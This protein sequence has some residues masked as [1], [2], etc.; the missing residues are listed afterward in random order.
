MKPPSRTWLLAGLMAAV[1]L[2]GWSITLRQA[3]SSTVLVEAGLVL[4]LPNA[5]ANDHPVT[6][7]W[8][9]AAQ[10]EGLSLQPMSDDA[11]VQALANHQSLPGVILPDT[12]HRQASDMLVNALHHY[13]QQGGQL[14]VAFDAALLDPQQ[15]A[16][17]A[18]QSRLSPL[19][20][21]VYA[22][23][24]QM[25]DATTA[26]GP[27][28]MSRKAE[29]TLAI[30]PGKLDFEGDQASAWGELTTYGYKT[31]SYSHYRTLPSD[32]S[33]TL[34][35][36]AQG[37]TVVSTHH[38]GQ[39]S[40]LFA[41]LPLG[42][43]KTQ[44][45]SYLL[46]RLLSHFAVAMVHQP[47]LA[48]T[49]GAQGGMVLNLHVDS[50]AAQ[51]HLQSLEAAGWFDQ[52]PYSI[53]I[54]AGPDTY[55]PGDHMGID[56]P[57]NPWMQGFL[58]RQHAKGHEIGNH[59]G[60]MHN[61]FGYG[62]TQDNRER[63]EPFL[64]LNHTAVSL[65]IGER[66]TSY[67]APMGN[68][69][70]W[71]TDWLAAHEFK[72][73]YTTSDSGL[74]PTRSYI[75]GQRATARRLWSFPIS[76][77]KRIATMDELHAHQIKESEINAFIEDLL[78]H[79]SREGIARLFYFHPP[80]SK[81]YSRTLETLSASAQK[82]QQ[83]GR[84]RWY[85]MGELSDFQNQRMAAHWHATSAPSTRK[86]TITANTDSTL[87][88]MAWLIP[89]SGGQGTP[90]ITQ[91]TGRVLERPGQWLVIAGDCQV[92]HIEWTEGV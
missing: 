27:V 49:P 4:L 88:Q 74:G 76:N 72:A 1:A 36:S 86:K 84:F 73:Y 11:F 2:I 68:Q 89:K 24:D 39:G 69:P 21:S 56:L 59:G 57:H 8:L 45:D 75:Q 62:V 55:T 64:S 61:V 19:V 6:Q 22:L 28:Y 10:E 7:A 65:A 91:G 40:V 83:Q 48:S 23:Y 41:N 71:V 53:H 78:A 32:R 44:T 67:S 79:V 18:P 20:G 15:G 13:V 38:H 66:A 54:T 70:D 50:N 47:I 3:N 87:N 77:F 14:L 16:Y 51:A 82:L 26:Q 81:E 92:L 31:L 30:Q 85:S 42:Y 80:I 60:W 34:V 35:K 17:A 12:V 5:Q 46:H 52:G 33:D 9:D 37:D 29:K 63:F 90:Q 43:L 25:G 58:Q